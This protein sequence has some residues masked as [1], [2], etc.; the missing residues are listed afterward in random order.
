[1]TKDHIRLTE[2]NLFNLLANT[3]KFTGNVPKPLSV[4]GDIKLWSGRQMLGTIFPPNVNVR[5]GNSSYDKDK[6]NGDNGNYVII[7]N[8]EFKQGCIDKTVFQDRTS[9]LV[10]TVFNENGSDEARLLFDNTQRIICDWLVQTGFSVGVSDL[11]IEKETTAEIKKAINDMKIKAYDMIRN[12]HMNNFENK[13]IMSNSEY[14]EQEINSLLNKARETAST[15]GLKNIS[16]D[17]R[18]L[19]MIRS[20]SKGNTVNVAQ[21]IATL[22]QQNVEGKRI[23][24]G[25]DDRTLPHFSRFD[26][27][28]ESRGFVENSFIKGLTPQELFFHAMGGREGLIDKVLVNNRER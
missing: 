13:S 24:Y 17:N 10:H 20:K 15:I 6:N 16:D 1:M 3:S 23:P 28:P 2:K 21:M 8:G 22:G 14:F 19:N 27:G 26:D 25:F 12:I 18:M 4:E 11:V 7:E 9:G 5:M